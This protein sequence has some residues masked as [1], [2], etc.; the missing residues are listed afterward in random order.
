MKTLT[1]LNA[2]GTQRLAQTGVDLAGVLQGRFG[3]QPLWSVSPRDV[4][5]VPLAQTFDQSVFI[6][7]RL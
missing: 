4:D 1:D 5:E 6:T 3:Q 7:H 2:S